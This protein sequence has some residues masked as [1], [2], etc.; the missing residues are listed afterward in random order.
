[1]L[2]F[3]PFYLQSFLSSV[4]KFISYYFILPTLN[5]CVLQAVTHCSSG[6]D[7]SLE[8]DF[9]KYGSLT[10]SG[11]LSGIRKKWRYKADTRS[12]KVAMLNDGANMPVKMKRKWRE[13]SEREAATSCPLPRDS[14]KQPS[15]PSLSKMTISHDTKTELIFINRVDSRIFPAPDYCLA[16]VPPLENFQP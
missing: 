9:R 4:L 11:N 10:V 6:W 13:L 14:R 15:L 1:M 5:R 16:M 2:I 8:N 3:L 7:L 12:K